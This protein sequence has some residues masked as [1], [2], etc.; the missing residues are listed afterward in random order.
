MSDNIQSKKMCT[1]IWKEKY[2]HWLLQ[3]IQHDKNTHLHDVDIL[4]NHFVPAA[5]F[6]IYCDW[7]LMLSFKKGAKN[8]TAGENL[9]KVSTG[10]T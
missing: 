8:E 9:Y 1:T 7:V 2:C 5:V 3:H 4:Q 10:Q 6:I